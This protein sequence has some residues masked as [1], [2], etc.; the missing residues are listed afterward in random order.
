MINTCFDDSIFHYDH[1]HKNKRVRLQ[2]G[3]VENHDGSTMFITEAITIEFEEEETVKLN[4]NSP[5]SFKGG[6]GIAGST[7]LI[8]GVVLWAA[9]TNVQGQISEVRTEVSTLRSDN[10]EDFNSV[11]SEVNSVRS[12]VNSVR[13]D[14]N[15]GFNR[16]NDKLDAMSSKTDEKIDKITNIINEMRMD[17]VKTKTQN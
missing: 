11:R 10:R 15:Q 6:L 12:E 14:M 5:L 17:Q 7:L 8:V 16:V 2:N 13:S 3:T 9:Y 4:P 1:T